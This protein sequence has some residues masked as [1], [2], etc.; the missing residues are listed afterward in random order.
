MSV[1]IRYLLPVV[2]C[3]LPGYALAHEAG[4][5]PLGSFI[6]GLTHPVLGPDHFLAMV[7]VGILSAQIGGRAIWT[8]PAT[9]VV[10][11]ALGG[12]LGMLEVPLSAVELGIAFSVLV[13]GIAIAVDR[14]LPLMLAMLAVGFFAVFHGY[15]HG[16]EM[17]LVAEPVR[18]AAG[19]MSGTAALHVLGVIIGDVPR[20]YASGKLVL[21]LIG[22]G[23][24]G[25]GS[26]FVLG[27]V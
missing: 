3:A 5:L 22:G 10:V 9:F 12:V 6:G 25:I 7:S 21:R 14:R 1:L 15:A 24:A 19:F 18:Y 4:S 23:I 11:M 27:M 2:L 20:H 8:V 26:W 16:T 13:L 17:P